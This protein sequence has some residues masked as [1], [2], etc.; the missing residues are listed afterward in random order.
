MTNEW[1][2]YA[3]N[4]H[5]RTPFKYPSNNN[6]LNTNNNSF[7]TTNMHHQPQQQFYN[8]MGIKTF[9]NNLNNNNSNALNQYSLMNKF[10]KPSRGELQVDQ[11]WK[12]IRRFRFWDRNNTR[13]WLIN[14]MHRVEP[15]GFFI[16]SSTLWH[17]VLWS[18]WH[19]A[20]ST[21]LFVQENFKI[22]QI[23]K[24]F[25][26]NQI[27]SFHPKFFCPKRVNFSLISLT[28]KNRPKQKTFPIVFPDPLTRW[29]CLCRKQFLTLSWNKQKTAQNVLPSSR[30]NNKVKFSSRKM[31]KY[32][33]KKL[34]FNWFFHG[35]KILWNKNRW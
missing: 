20:I 12:R 8:K 3:E 32:V 25:S 7:L 5:A 11:V 9:N 1:I 19:F 6:S 4:V 23:H 18:F 14:M 26:L 30:I 10:Q 21:K 24:L 2:D 29:V 33:E 15:L 17:D 22:F 34:K 13:F 28:V 16:G 31:K 27:P 35:W